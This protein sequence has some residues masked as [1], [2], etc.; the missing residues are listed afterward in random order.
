MA[1][2]ERAEENARDDQIGVAMRGEEGTGTMAGSQEG[3]VPGEGTRSQASEGAVTGGIL[4]GVLGAAAALLI[5]ASA[6]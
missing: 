1:G 6:R 5:P 4:G 2:A 3:S